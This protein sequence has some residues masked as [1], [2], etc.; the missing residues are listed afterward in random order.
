MRRRNPLTV[1]RW[2]FAIMVALSVLL[3]PS[4]AS[5]DMAAGSHD[6]QIMEAVHCHVPPNSTGHEKMG[7][8]SRCIAMCTA[9]AVAPWTPIGATP[10]RQQIAQFPV[11]RSYRSVH[12]ELATP[13]PRYS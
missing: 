8:K 7:S 5:A 12:A 10:P 13:P 3:A 6:M 2:F 1:V 4:V 11:P 9:L